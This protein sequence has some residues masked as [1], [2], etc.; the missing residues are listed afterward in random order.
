MKTTTKKK[1]DN[2][3]YFDYNNRQHRN[4]LS[5]MR[6]ANWVCPCPNSRH[7]EVA[8]IKRLSE[9]LKS[10]KSPVKKPLKEMSSK[11]LSKVITAFEGIVNHVYK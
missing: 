4:I 2:W 11:E 1:V 5:L 7:G 8:D 3:G 6:Q 9:F 10:E